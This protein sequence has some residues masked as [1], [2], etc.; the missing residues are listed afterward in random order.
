VSTHTPAEWAAALSLGTGAYAAGAALL[1][2]FVDADLPDVR[3]L[4]ENPAGDRLL[5]IVA[6]VR[7][8]AGEAGRRAA[9]HTAALLLLLSGPKEALR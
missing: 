7:D 3:R 6:A 5:V 2:A 9:L 8:R 4:I 1:L